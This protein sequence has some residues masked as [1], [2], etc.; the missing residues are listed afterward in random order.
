MSAGSVKRLTALFAALVIIAACFCGCGEKQPEFDPQAAFERLL[1]EVK[2]DATLQD[3]SE[4][5][6]YM[7][8]D[9][10]EGASVKMYAAGGQHEDAVIMLTAADES[11]LPAL[12]SAVK[13]YIDSRL[14]ETDRY[15][16]SESPK[17]KNAVMY[18]GGNTVIVCVT[19]DAETAQSILH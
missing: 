6:E 10:P 9:L 18:S 19:N 8:Y 12:E 7:F 13:D 1:V 14:Y 4:M 11:G 17:L 15:T 16:P 2:Y 3:M 5:A